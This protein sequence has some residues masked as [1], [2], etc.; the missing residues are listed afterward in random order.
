MEYRSGEI[1][2]DRVI[3]MTGTVAGAVG[4]AILV[5]IAAA[6]AIVPTFTASLVSI[7]TTNSA[8]DSTQIEI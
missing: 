1:A 3:H 8:V 6:V 4:S 5:G 2:A 7:R